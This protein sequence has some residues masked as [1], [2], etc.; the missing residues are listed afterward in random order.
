MGHGSYS[1]ESRTIRATKS[2]YYHKSTNEIFDQRSINN[3]MNPFGV[4][5][6]ESRDSE[7]HP[8]SL[9]VIVALDETGSMGS[10]PAYLVKDGLNQ[11]MDNI[12]DGG[13]PDPQVL[14]LG[15]GDHESDQ[16]PLQVGQFESSDE[17][18]DTWLTKVY[19]E[20]GGGGNDGESYHLAHY[21][22][23][24]HTEMDCLDKRGRKG[25]LFTIGD[26]PVL[27]TLPAKAIKKIMGPGQ[28]EDYTT[29]QLIAKAAERYNVFH[30][31]VTATY[32]GSRQK[33]MDGWK[34]LLKDH[35][36]IVDKPEDI[37]NVIART[38][39]EF[40]KEEQPTTVNPSTET[41]KDE[42]FLY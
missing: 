29:E 15:I 7:E 3:A 12:I 40:G 9:A 11:M 36:L 16:A 28:Y 32:S 14:F 38:I 1:S 34:Q 37:S 19:L 23:A 39:I 4:K 31:H 26:E 24:F 27:P 21:F 8:E 30:I 2:G 10:V 13:E 17:L 6:R 18:L 25:F 22:A 41:S 42:N 20:G 33:V 5:V 35:L